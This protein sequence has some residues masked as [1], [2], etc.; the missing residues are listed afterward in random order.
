LYYQIPYFPSLN[1]L[2][3]FQYRNIRNRV[4]LAKK[5]KDWA[6]FICCHERPYRLQAFGEVADEL[7]DKTYWELLREIYVDSENLWQYR[8]LPT[9]LKSKRKGR[10]HLMDD[11]E[12]RF[13]EKQPE[14]LEIFRGVQEAAYA[15]RWS[16]TLNRRK[17][18]WFAK[19]YPHGTPILVTATVAKKCVIG[20]F[21]HRNESEIVVDPRHLKNV[22]LRIL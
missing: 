18:V 21:S 13:L 2:C 16:W 12:R 14:R 19:R 15:R 9:L 11:D 3:N 8:E 4:E 17:G 6:T 1:A 10:K 20:Y 22:V 5:S 7:D